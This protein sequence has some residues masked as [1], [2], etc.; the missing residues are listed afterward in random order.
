MMPIEP[1]PIPVSR[2]LLPRFEQLEQYLRTIDQAR[3]YTNHGQ[4]HDLLQCRISGHYHIGTDCI[5]LSSSGTSGLI[6]TILATVG[7][8]TNDR[9][10]CICPAHT[11]VATAIA[12]RAC[13]YVPFLADVDEDSWALHPEQLIEIPELQNASLVLVAAPYGRQPDLASWQRFQRT[14]GLPVIID[15]AACFDGLPARTISEGRIPAV[16]SLHATKTLSTAEGGLI[17]GP[18]DI[19]SRV[20]RALNFGFC[21][22]RDSVGPSI[23][24]KMSEYHA[25]IGLADLDAW[26][27]KRRGFIASARNYSSTTRSAGLDSRIA[28]MENCANPYALFAAGSAK[29]G[30]AVTLPR[31]LI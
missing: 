24:G 1:P 27:N 2:P 8:A 12:A 16:V 30:A 17:I 31:F 28:V 21:D 6:G 14:S 23:N 26:D 20:V 7:Y 9:P 25:A 10:L 18:P 11:F 13:G 29:E 22:S 19:V 5:A 3:Y 4:L 15:A